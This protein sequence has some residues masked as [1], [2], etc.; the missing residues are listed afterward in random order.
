MVAMAY[1]PGNIDSIEGLLPFQGKS[2]KYGEAWN[3]FSKESIEEVLYG[4]ER[5]T[6]YFERKKAVS[7]ETL[8]LNW[9]DQH[10]ELIIRN[11]DT[12]IPR[13][14]L[15]DYWTAYSQYCDSRKIT[16][17]KRN[18]LDFTQGD[19]VYFRY[20]YRGDES[21][22]NDIAKKIR[23]MSGKWNPKIKG[24]ALTISARAE[25]DPFLIFIEM[26]NLINN[27]LMWLWKVRGERRINPETG[28]LKMYPRKCNYMWSIE[29][30]KRGYIH[31]HFV[32]ETKRILPPGMKKEKMVEWWQSQGIDIQGPGIDI[33][34]VRKDVIRYIMK[35]ITKGQTSGEWN[36][37]LT[38]T[39]KRGWGASRGLTQLDEGMGLST[40]KGCRIIQTDIEEDDKV[41]LFVGV[42]SND[43]IKWIS[44]FKEPPD[45][46]LLQDL[47]KYIG[48][49][50]NFTLK[51][52]L[53]E[54]FF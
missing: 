50:D 52:N 44:T 35:Y 29:P 54:E 6:G 24:Q 11:D 28:R 49:P 41:W 18:N 20:K 7:L 26:K 12:R 45:P 5:M 16:F 25:G 42:F 51:P 40:P 17:F 31:F 22:K 27:F 3:Y 9:R 48:T 2:I 15:A 8:G 43:F 36:A 14:Y 34:D 33:S 53:K 32:F 23:R 37:L 47:W 1:N 19:L 4:S 46:G 30:T 38:M 39:R 13:E 21:Y 10:G